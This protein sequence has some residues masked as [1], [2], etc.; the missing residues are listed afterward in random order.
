MTVT[1]IALPMP[2]CMEHGKE[3]E[4]GEGCCDTVAG[5]STLNPHKGEPMI[6]TDGVLFSA[7]GMHESNKKD[8]L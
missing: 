1:S 8:S 4:R 7:M 2:L 5:L 3:E 6:E